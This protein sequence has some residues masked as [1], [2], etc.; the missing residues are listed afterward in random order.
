MSAHPESPETLRARFTA[1]RA[2][3]KRAKDAAQHIGI[4]E[5]E[6]VAAHCGV[7]DHAPKAIPLRKPY[8]ELLQALE[9]CGPLMGL[10]RN[11]NV[12]HEK[13]GVYEKVS[14]QGHMG[15]ALGGDID[16][17]LF[18]N[19]WHAGYAVTELTAN[20]GNRANIS[21]QFFDLHGKAVHKIFQREATDKDAWQAI[22]ENFSEPGT[23]YSFTPLGHIASPKTAP[24][25]DA[26]FDAKALAEDWAAMQDTHEFFGLLS[27]HAIQRQQS[28]RLVEG[29]FT[30]RVA[31]GA[32]RE[33]LLEAAFDGTSI[34]VF[35]SSGGCI[36][37]HT[38]PVQR[39]EPIE[40]HGAPWLNVLDP[41]FNLHLRED[42]IAHVWVVEK[43]T[44]DGIVT[45]LEAF[46]TQ[47][48]L[49]V[50]FFGARKPG[51]VEMQGWRDILAKLPHL[52]TA[53]TVAAPLASREK[54][55]A[56]A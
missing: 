56:A 53:L 24:T 22:A 29:Q 26:E 47:G 4:S 12:V 39:I 48:E 54:A 55:H 20:P 3:G 45:S 34:M 21:L 9:L 46:D 41:N 27:K 14:A 18:L 17:R 37:I 40:V 35:V 49:M 6:A 11:E 13:T 1:A 42:R 38:G 23:H 33:M 16:L 2:M 43:P 32:V 8:I 50:M 36:Q 52:A 5:G 15:L 19:K 51:S 30:H 10:T 44:A 7:H 31:P 28:F 25:L